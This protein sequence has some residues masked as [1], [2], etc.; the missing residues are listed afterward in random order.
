MAT[1]ACAVHF[2]TRLRFMTCVE[3]TDPDITVAVTVMGK[4]PAGVPGLLGFV[5][6]LPPPHEDKINAKQNNS[7]RASSG[8]H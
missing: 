4:V 2:T 1:Y 5:E 8:M 6:E 7:A 3:A